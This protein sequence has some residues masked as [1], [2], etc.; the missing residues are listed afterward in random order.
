MYYA[1]GQLHSGYI[2][3]YLHDAPHDMFILHLENFPRSITKYTCNFVLITIL[4][5]CK[6]R[7]ANNKFHKHYRLVMSLNLW[8]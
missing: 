6:L 1:Y 4:K 5:L 3:T 2:P 7:T 8:M